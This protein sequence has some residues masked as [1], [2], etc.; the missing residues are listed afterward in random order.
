MR[1]MN[2]TN[3]IPMVSV[4]IPVYNTEKYLRECLDSVRNQSLTAIEILC[5]DDGSSDQ[6]PA[7]LEQYAQ[8]DDRI[9]VI[10]QSNSGPSAARNNGIDRA[11]GRYIYFLDADDV[12][13]PGA[14]DSLYRESEKLALDVLYFDAEV[15]FEDPGLAAQY[16]YYINYYQ[17][18][19]DY[20]AVDSG[21]SLF[22][23]LWSARELIVQPCLQL[24]KRQFLVDSGVRF[25][26]GIFHADELFTLSLMLKAKRVS[27][28]A[29]VHYIRRIRRNSII[30]GNRPVE[31]FR[32]YLTCYSG[33]LS[34]AKSQQYDQPVRR[35]LVEKITEI[36]EITARKYALLPG[37]ECE[38]YREL[39][40]E[41][42]SSLQVLINPYTGTHI[43]EKDG[44][45]R[46]LLSN[47]LQKMRFYREYLL[48]LASGR[49]NREW[50][51]QTYP[52]VAA[53]GVDPI[54][55]YIT[56]GWKEGRD[57]SPEFS[58]SGYLAQHAGSLM[59]D[60]NPFMH[61]LRSL[62]S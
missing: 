11:R 25:F 40:A 56:N 27:H 54:F 35:A 60:C 47:M 39:M 51:L 32:G 42:E 21:R 61:Y 28:S 43:E 44:N 58:T 45:P 49:F 15:V 13:K 10:T 30:T 5:I 50:Y 20:S 26:D 14:L 29:S 6:C 41:N 23:R 46:S 52:D 62:R 37:E 7:I 4:I 59:P 53:A 16:A 48:I 55:H 33:M 36:S 19:G 12:L 3:A 2:P 34:L 9:T 31:D 18:S 1:I 38:K 17:R 24:I 8:Q 22:A 57:P